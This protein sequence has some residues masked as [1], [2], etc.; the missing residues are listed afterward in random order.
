MCITFMY[1][2]SFSCFKLKMRFD[3]FLN[4]ARCLGRRAGPGGCSIGGGDLV[5]GVECAA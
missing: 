2:A 1:L 5:L 3:C 4:S